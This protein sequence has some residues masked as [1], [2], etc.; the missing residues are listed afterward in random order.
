MTTHERP[1]AIDREAAAAPLA[2]NQK[3]AAELCGVS[4]NHFKKHI[5]PYIKCVYVGGVRRWLVTT[6]EDWL[7]GQQA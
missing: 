3:A 6:L 5:R 2:V 7:K 1:T 4:V